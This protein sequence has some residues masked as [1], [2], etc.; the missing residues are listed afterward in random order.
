MK[1]NGLI[2]TMALAMIVC[3]VLISSEAS[4]ETFL[5]KYCWQLQEITD[6]TVPPP[7]NEL[8][9]CNVYTREGGEFELF[10]KDSI[11]TLS[12]GHSVIVGS[13]IHVYQSF[14]G[15]DAANNVIGMGGM[16]SK[17]DG[18]TLNGTWDMFGNW[19]GMSAHLTGTS[20]L[21]ACP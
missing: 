6:R 14:G 1:K 21:I 12:H 2:C 8:V 7:N 15:K 11:P 19:N 20:T 13:E 16:L 10:C 4:A 18:M 17:L 3:A 5:G 9:E